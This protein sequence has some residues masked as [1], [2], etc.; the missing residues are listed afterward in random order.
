MSLLFFSFCVDQH[1]MTIVALARLLHWQSTELVWPSEAFYFFNFILKLGSIPL[2]LKFQNFI[3]LFD[4]CLPF[5]VYS[6]QS[7]LC[8]PPTFTLTG[9]LL[10]LTNPLPLLLAFFL[11][12]LP[13]LFT[14]NALII[15]I[16]LYYP[17]FFTTK[18]LLLN[19]SP[20]LFSLQLD[21]G[22]LCVNSIPA[23]VP[24]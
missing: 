20:P 7:N 23:T 1:N 14:F 18:F 10:L 19:F 12:F 13:F 4:S 24:G 22:S 2:L 5:V 16:L 21:R 9:T 6:L 3:L 15:L 11:V 8:L 17:L